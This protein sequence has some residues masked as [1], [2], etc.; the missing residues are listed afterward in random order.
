MKE[1][2]DM[3]WRLNAVVAL[4]AAAEHQ[5]LDITTAT[6]VYIYIWDIEDVSDMW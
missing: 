3:H 4:S 1:L 6:M 2:L 5:D